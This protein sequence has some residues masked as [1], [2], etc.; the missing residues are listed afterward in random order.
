MRVARRVGQLGILLLLNEDPQPDRPVVSPD[1]AA[2]LPEPERRLVATI[3]GRRETIAFE[4]WQYRVVTLAAA[5]ARSRRDDFETV[6]VD[7]ARV[8]MA[9][10]AGSP[11]FSPEQRDAL[12][13]AVDRLV[14]FR[15]A[16]VTGGLVLLRRPM[17]ARVKSSAAEPASTPSALR[18]AAK[19]DITLTFLEVGTGRPL[20]GAALVLAAPDGSESRVTTS[21]T[22][23]ITLTGLDPGQCV[24]TSIIKNATLD[25]SFVPGSSGPPRAGGREARLR[26]S[27]RGWWRSTKFA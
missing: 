15:Q 19:K 24:A 3:M 13:E 23:T 9:R 4:G 6:R 26:C 16:G 8:A 7:D 17:R 10:L 12:K 21:S 18:A 25:A 11:S 27:R 20:A 5:T 14:D 2:A 1:G 22:G